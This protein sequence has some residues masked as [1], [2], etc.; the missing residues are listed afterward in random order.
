MPGGSGGGM[1]ICGGGL[2]D[3]KRLRTTGFG[4]F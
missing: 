1:P 4:G 3:V 2:T